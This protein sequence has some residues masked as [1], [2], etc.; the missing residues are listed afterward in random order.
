MQA[1]VL[2]GEKEVLQE[3]AE[4]AQARLRET[5]E[6]MAAQIKELSQLQHL[7]PRLQDMQDQVGHPVIWLGH[8]GCCEADRSSCPGLKGHAETGMGFSIT[9]SD[10][11]LV[12]AVPRCTMPALPS[13]M[14][15]GQVQNHSFR[16]ASPEPHELVSL[17]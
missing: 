7:P 6:S 16:Q 10:P 5:R 15:Q 2:E 4:A 14:L 1:S 17:Q 11:A 12:R 3:A 9:A 13:K 8:H